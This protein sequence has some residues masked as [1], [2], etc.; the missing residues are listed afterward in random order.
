MY[1]SEFW[2]PISFIGVYCA[3]LGMSGFT[4][5][6]F[7]ESFERDV[8][9]IIIIKKKLKKL[10]KIK[11]IYMLCSYCFYNPIAFGANGCFA[12]VVTDVFGDETIGLFQLWI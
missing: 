7:I 8:T 11:I 9:I 2:S 1:Q 12:Q 3:A 6:Q 5:Q 4:T 10:K